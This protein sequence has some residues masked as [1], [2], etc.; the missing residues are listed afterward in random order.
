MASIVLDGLI[1]R[2]RYLE[3]TVVSKNEETGEY[4]ALARDYGEDGLILET[5]K[6]EAEA[7]VF[8]N[9]IADK[10]I[11]HDGEQLIDAR[12]PDSAPKGA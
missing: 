3:N 10:M 6:T 12:E 4:S 5:F 2:D 1:I 11:A 8:I 7:K 9:K